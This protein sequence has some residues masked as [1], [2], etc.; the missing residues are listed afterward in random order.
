MTLAE[1]QA[2]RALYLAAEAAILKGQEYRI[3]D[4]GVDRY[5]RRAD[6]DV[7]RSTLAEI[8]SQIAAQDTTTRR[9]LYLR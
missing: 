4:G 1:L 7:V 9:V 2:R 5:L 3:R 8:D 6:L